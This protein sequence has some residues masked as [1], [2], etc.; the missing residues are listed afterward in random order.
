MDGYRNEVA[1]PQEV[2]DT[3]GFLTDEEK[4]HLFRIGLQGID[5]IEIA[6]WKEF[7]DRIA[8]EGHVMGR[9]DVIG[10]GWG[11]CESQCHSR[12]STAVMKP[13]FLSLDMKGITLGAPPNFLGCPLD[14]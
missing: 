12:F 11:E 2:I 7:A 5:G 1:Q 3:P 10:A 6:Q 8:L 13:Q 14:P 9:L 4:A